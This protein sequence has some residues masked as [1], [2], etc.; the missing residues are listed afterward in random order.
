MI[1]TIT[2]PAYVPMVPPPLV[3]DFGE[4]DQVVLDYFCFTPGAPYV[5]AIKFVRVRFGCGLKEAKDVVDKY[6]EMYNPNSINNYG[7]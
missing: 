6:R 5:Q 3:Y 2:V 7:R 4:S 1:R